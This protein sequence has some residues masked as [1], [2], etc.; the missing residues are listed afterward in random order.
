M[1]YFCTL[2]PRLGRHLP[3]S[4]W[5]LFRAYRLLGPEGDGLGD[6]PT[7]HPESETVKP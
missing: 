2:T 6:I 7:E 3:G 1:A 4:S 5:L